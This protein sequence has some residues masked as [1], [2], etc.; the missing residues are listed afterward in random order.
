MAI[1]TSAEYEVSKEQFIDFVKNKNPNLENDLRNMGVHPSIMNLE[2]YKFG[3]KNYNINAPE[4]KGRIEPW[5]LATKE[6][7]IKP[8]ES[9][10]I[11]VGWLN[12]IASWGID[13]DSSNILKSAYANSITGFVDKW[14]DGKKKDIK[15]NSGDLPF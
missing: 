4:Y 14:E 13:D 12:S 7:D 15:S 8:I 3:A 11:D 9:K 10:D 5:E 2:I 6:R 1:Q